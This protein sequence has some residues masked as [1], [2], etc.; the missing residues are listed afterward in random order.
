M[1]AENKLYETQ[2]VFP[3]EELDLYK[4]GGKCWTVPVSFWPPRNKEIK[5]FAAVADYVAEEK[6]TLL[7]IGCGNAFLSYLL[8]R[9]SG[10]KVIG[11][12]PVKKLLQA[13]PY[14]HENLELVEGTSQ[15]AVMM[16]SRQNT[17]VVLCSWMPEGVD[18]T[19]DIQKI[20][21]K[22]IIYVKNKGGHTGTKGSFSC[23]A[24]YHT[25][26]QWTYISSNEVGWYFH[27]LRDKVDP[28]LSM[29]E[30]GCREDPN[31]R[32]FFMEELH[33][34]RPYKWPDDNVIEIQL[35]NDIS[36]P[37]LP[38]E[39]G[40]ICKYRWESDLEH[41]VKSIKRE[42]ILGPCEPPVVEA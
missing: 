17:D 25:L 22:A 20:R 11:L 42:P 8:A 28:H 27:Q 38:L 16:Y 1:H 39:I 26:M 10:L 32:K 23:G 19:E 3:F 4:L 40:S 34:M 9:E 12:G 15:D 18:L 36:D 14:K 35:R 30:E 37:E 6:P 24:E 31:W 13:T 33:V 5:F 2:E 7:D 21:P 41:L 29:S